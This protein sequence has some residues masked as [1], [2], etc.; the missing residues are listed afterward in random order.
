MSKPLTVEELGRNLMAPPIGLKEGPI[1]VLVVAALLARAQ[2]V[3]V[4]EEGTFV[5]YLSSD[6]IDRLVKN[7]ARFSIRNFALRGA[8]A[9]VVAELARVLQVEQRDRPQQRAS[10]IIGV[11]SPLL[12][13]MRNLPPYA[14]RTRTLSASTLGLRSALLSAREPDQLL[15]A[16]LPTA[17]G[18]APIAA[19]KKTEPG[20]VEA[21]AEAL[22]ASVQEL[23]GAYPTLLN[24]FEASLAQH[25]GAPGDSVRDDLRVRAERLNGQ[26]IDPTLRAVATALST[27]DTSREAWLEQLGMVVSRTSPTS[28]TDDDR[29]NALQ[30]LT[31]CGL[32]FRRVE[33]LHFTQTQL[34]GAFDAVRVAVTL[35]DGTDS[36]TVVWADQHMRDELAELLNDAIAMSTARL[37]SK[38]PEMLLSSLARAVLID[39]KT[40]QADT[41]QGNVDREA[42]NG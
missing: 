39:E 36:A 34:A 28:W 4:Y 8:R 3:G 27:R 15:F 32:A 7:P 14:L 2:E 41:N 18:F 19:N 42:T 10:T 35:P 13:A 17:L 12:R 29:A 16:A 20:V 38:G 30:A 31:H 5:G 22:E 6:V 26:L 24:T 1:P 11:V 33:S 9:K 21:Y 40:D 37:G 23:E 25:F